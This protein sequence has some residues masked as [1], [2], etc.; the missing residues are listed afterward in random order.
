MTVSSST[1]ERSHKPITRLMKIEF[2][3]DF[4]ACCACWQKARTAIRLW[5]L[6]CAAHRDKPHYGLPPL[7]L[8]RCLDHM[9]GSSCTFNMRP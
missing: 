7:R 2:C 9:R 4:E 8:I 3:E 6:R 5:V 1:I